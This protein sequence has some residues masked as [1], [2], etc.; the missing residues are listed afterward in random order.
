M[1]ENTFLADLQQEGRIEPPVEEQEGEKETTPESPAEKEPKE[2]EP[3][4]QP[5]KDK[6][7]GEGDEKPEGEPKEGEEPA[8]FQAFHK[9]P[10]WKALNDELGTLRQFRDEVA[11]LLPLI[12]K[13]SE[14]G[15]IEDEAEMPDWFKDVVGDNK[16]VWAKYKRYS[17]DER[18]NLRSEILNEL[19]QKQEAIVGETKK[20]EEWL[21]GE[22]LKLNEVVEEEKLP[23]YDR[24]ELLKVAVEFKPTDDKGNISLRRAYDILQMQKG[25][26]ELPKSD[27]KKII[28]DKTIGKSKS[29]TDRKDYKTSDDLRGKS[30][31]DLIPD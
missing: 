4:S 27:D 19:Q 26:K 11:P 22:I 23:K 2:N 20:Q 12:K 24:N 7:E 15:V 10:R 8:V 21:D 16:E 18:K 13:L 29:D 28:A 30:F 14:P 25:K 3:E 17:A 6:P 31:H 1:E 5:G 9:H